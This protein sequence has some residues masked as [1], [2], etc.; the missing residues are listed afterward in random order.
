MN[1]MRDIFPDIQIRGCYYHYNKAIWR[2]AKKLGANKTKE[3]RKIIRLISMVPLLPAHSIRNA[4]L[5]I[6]DD[7]PISV[8]LNKFQKYFYRQW[9]KI[10]TDVLSCADDKHRT[11]NALEAWHR[12]VNARIPKTPNLF[13][14]LYALKR[15]AIHFDAKIR[16]SLF[17]TLKK[18]RRAYLIR[19]DRQYKILLRKFKKQ[20]IDCMKFL[21][22]IIHLRLSIRT[23]KR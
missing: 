2:N 23:K 11:T 1:A 10:Q 8:E 15:E 9:L 4:C 3:C 5:L 12:R 17:G 7:A 22:N 13:L 19:F 14:F 6:W 21:K 20:K 16:Q 18:N